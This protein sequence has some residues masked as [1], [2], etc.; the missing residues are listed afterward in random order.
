M[1]FYTDYRKNIYSSCRLK[2]II[3]SLWIEPNLNISKS[4]QTTGSTLGRDTMIIVKT[5]KYYLR[6][7][8][9]T[10]WALLTLMTSLPSLSA[11]T[12]GTHWSTDTL[13]TLRSFRPSNEYMSCIGAC[14]KA[15]YM[16]LNGKV[17]IFVVL[18]IYNPKHSSSHCSTS[19]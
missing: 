7:P 11:T 15:F 18:I 9:G 16:C 14:V 6:W 5:K 1:H 17:I 12:L 2:Y 13:N 4:R 8:V 3:V 19:F 10:Y